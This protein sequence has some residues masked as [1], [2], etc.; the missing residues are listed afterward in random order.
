[1]DQDFFALSSLLQFGKEVTH[2]LRGGRRLF[3]HVPYWGNNESIINCSED[4]SLRKEYPLL[5]IQYVLKNGRD[6]S[7]H[8]ESVENINVIELGRGDSCVVTNEH[9]S[10][11][12]DSYDIVFKACHLSSAT[13][14][15]FTVL[16]M[17]VQNF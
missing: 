1:M 10:F 15:E 12:G 6:H 11:I 7:Q 5:S 2:E 17:V 9:L 14:V 16:D 13:F 4:K 3:V 8:H